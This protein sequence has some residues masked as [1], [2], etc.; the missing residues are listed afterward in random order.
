MRSCSEP[1]SALSSGGI[2]WSSLL[3]SV[4]PGF[5]AP[6]KCG[7]DGEAV[8]AIGNLLLLGCYC[9]LFIPRGAP[10]LC[11]VRNP[12]FIRSSAIL[13]IWIPV[14]G[15]T[16]REEGS[17]LLQ[18]SSAC[19]ELSLFWSCPC[20]SRTFHGWFLGTSP[21]YSWFPSLPYTHPGIPW[22]RNLL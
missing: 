3:L 17:A 21:S 19:M 10:L 7:R 12:A 14:T 11:E 22:G 9:N 16:G 18:M 1:C 15:R 4:L 2:C 5:S 13:S 8:T 20:F 6:W